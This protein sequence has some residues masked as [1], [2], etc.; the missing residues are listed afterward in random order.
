MS[1]KTSLI[2]YFAD[3][4]GPR[5]ERAKLYGLIDI[6][7][8]TISAVICGAEGWADIEAFGKSKEEWLKQFLEL[9]N[10]TPSHDT[11]SRVFERLDAEAF[12]ERFIAWVAS[13]CNAKILLG[14]AFGAN[15]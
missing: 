6:L 7:V 5:F 2:S 13:F 9:E 3:L 1:E 4:P 12:E 15:A 11:I 14:V 10:G 8:L